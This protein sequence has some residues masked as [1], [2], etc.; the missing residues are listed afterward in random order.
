MA[1][2]YFSNL[3]YLNPVLCTSKWYLVLLVTTVPLLRVVNKM[4]PDK[5][6]SSNLFRTTWFLWVPETSVNNNSNNVDQE[7]LEPKDLPLV[8]LYR[9]NLKV[10]P[11]LLEGL[12]PNLNKGVLRCHLTHKHADLNILL[13]QGTKCLGQCQCLQVR[14]YLP[15]K[16]SLKV[17]YKPPLNSWRRK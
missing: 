4:V 15:S 12:T 8:L 11:L 13:Q 14:T 16:V 9:D 7:G 6:G 3:E 1:S 5:A 10:F 17:A 2:P